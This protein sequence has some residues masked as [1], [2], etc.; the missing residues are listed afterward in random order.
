[1][2]MQLRILSDINSQFSGIP[3]IEVENKVDILRLESTRL[4]I[5]AIEKKGIEDLK[6]AILANF[7][8]KS[9]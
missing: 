6:E 9:I 5:S 4:K 2:D 1:M 7:H 3:I 8:E